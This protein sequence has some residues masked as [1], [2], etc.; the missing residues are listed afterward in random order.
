MKPCELTWSRLDIRP[1][2]VFDPNLNVHL[3][4]W[5]GVSMTRSAALGLYSSF[6]LKI[7]ISAKDLAVIEEDLKRALVSGALDR[8]EGIWKEFMRRW[9]QQ[10]IRTSFFSLLSQCVNGQEDMFELLR[11]RYTNKEILDFFRE[12]RMIV[13]E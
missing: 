6:Y 13:R 11:E 4:Y 8:E 2:L 3:C 5:N 10:P 12:D 9:D 7:K 1:I